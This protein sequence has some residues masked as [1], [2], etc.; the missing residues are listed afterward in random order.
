MLKTSN[1]VISNWEN[2]INKPDVDMFEYLCGALNVTPNYLL[3]N[4]SE[5]ETSNLLSFPGISP[6]PKMKKVPLL[7]RIACGQP[8]LAEENF[9]GYINVPDGVEADFTLQCQGDSMINARIFDGDMVFIRQQPDVD[10]GEIAAVL[11]EREATLKRVYKQ[12]GKL[13]LMPENSSYPPM[14]YTGIE[15]NQIHIIGK[16]VAFLSVVK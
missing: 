14:V 3:G 1:T 8:I 6:M 9:E 15:L 5:L 12:D 7:G 11:I 16:A 13:T 4:S 10:N 2:N